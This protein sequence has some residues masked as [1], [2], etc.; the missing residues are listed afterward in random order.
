MQTRFKKIKSLRKI[1]KPTAVF[2]LTVDRNSNFF[3]S[4]QLVHN[5]SYACKY[6]LPPKTKIQMWNGIKKNI[7]KI[8]EGDEVVSLNTYNSLLIEEKSIVQKIMSRATEDLI[9]IKRSEEHT[10][11][12]QSQSN[13]VCRLLL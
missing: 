3:A 12:L 9:V 8:K 13:L 11:E 10:S 5:C 2:D 7:E 1:S 6:C 4:S